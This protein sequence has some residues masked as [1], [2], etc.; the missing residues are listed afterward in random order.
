MRRHHG[1]AAGQT[2]VEFSLVVGVVLV[3]LLGSLQVGLYVLER[4]VA[5]T[6]T[7]KGVRAAAAATGSPVDGPA[8]GTVFSTVERPLSSGLIGAHSQWRDPVGGRC[9]ALDDSWPVGVVYV[10][11][12]ASSTAGTVEVAVRGWVPA[13]VPPTFGLTSARGGALPLDFDAVVHTAVFAP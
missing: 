1:A 9:A 8:T 6:A 12:V 7:E 11:S 3:L 2:T 5:V 10:C 13:L 4:S